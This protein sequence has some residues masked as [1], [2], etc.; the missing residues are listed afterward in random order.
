MN[1]D[2]R[3]D[4]CARS[5]HVAQG[6]TRRPARDV[7]SLNEGRVP[8][9]SLDAPKD[10]LTQWLRQV[11]LGQLACRIPYEC[12][13]PLRSNATRQARLKAEAKRKL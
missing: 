1:L 12:T 9:V 2:F 3:Y 7:P 4:A 5:S 10:M 11:A 13:P 8:L 6:A